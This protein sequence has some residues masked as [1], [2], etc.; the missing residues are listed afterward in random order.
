MSGQTSF[1]SSVEGKKDFWAS[2]PGPYL[3]QSTLTSLARNIS[4]LELPPS[5]YSNTFEDKVEDEER[6]ASESD[7]AGTCLSVRLREAISESSKNK[8]DL[9][10]DDSEDD[11]ENDFSED[12]E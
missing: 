11:S 1:T 10:S 6:L 9:D 7:T 5:I 8:G 3:R 12:D 4:G 2:S